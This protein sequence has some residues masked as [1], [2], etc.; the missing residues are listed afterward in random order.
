MGLNQ[1][2]KTTLN[3]E[4]FVT[5]VGLGT[6]GNR[7]SSHWILEPEVIRGGSQQGKRDVK[8]VELTK[9]D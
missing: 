6:T 5:G 4:R 8:W 2:N 1:R 9:M 7:L 3:T